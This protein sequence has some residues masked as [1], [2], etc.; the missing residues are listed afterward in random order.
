MLPS[1]THEAL[2]YL[3]E[4]HFQTPSGEPESHARRKCCSG[5]RPW[6][7]GSSMLFETTKWVRNGPRGGSPGCAEDRWAPVKAEAWSYHIRVFHLLHIRGPCPH[8]TNDG[9][10]AS[11]HKVRRL[12]PRAALGTPRCLLKREPGIFS[13][14]T[15]LSS[16]GLRAGPAFPFIQ[17]NKC[18][19]PPPHWVSPLSLPCQAPL[20]QATL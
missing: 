8:Q 1:A 13:Q 11:D 6:S 16:P 20:P 19:S 3:R 7:H 5:R 4:K 9:T 15:V 18:V 17:S 14:H 10:E 2:Q 12:R